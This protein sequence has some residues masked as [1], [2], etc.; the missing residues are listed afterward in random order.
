MHALF[1]PLSQ[2]F[3]TWTM[4]SPR[5]VTLFCFEIMKVLV[6]IVTL[7]SVQDVGDFCS[8]FTDNFF[9]IAQ[10]LTN[11]ALLN[12]DKIL[13]IIGYSIEYYE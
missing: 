2:Y 9:R 6:K 11:L 3:M 1:V 4:R 8:M 5:Q 13:E 10:E 12:F 7:H